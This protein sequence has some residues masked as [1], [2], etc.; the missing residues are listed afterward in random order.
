[1]FLFKPVSDVCNLIIVYPTKLKKVCLV[2]NEIYIVLNKIFMFWALNFSFGVFY[3]NT[4]T[5]L[6][7]SNFSLT[8]QVVSIVILYHYLI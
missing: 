6:L 8:C 1:M 3:R 2:Q 4:L 7:Q 5:I